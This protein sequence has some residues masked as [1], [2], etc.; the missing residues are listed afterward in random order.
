MLFVK[1]KLSDGISFIKHITFKKSFNFCKIQCSYLLSL[2][3]KRAVFWGVPYS[4]SIEPTSFC[5]LNCPECPTGMNSLSRSSGIMDMNTFKRIIDN[6]NKHLLFINLYFQGEP[7]IN[8]LFF[9]FISY[10]SNKNIY[11]STSTNGHFLNKDFSEKIIE[12][13]LDRIIISLD[14][15]DQ[16]TYTSYRKNGKLDL[17]IE[18]IKNLVEAKK[19]KKSFKPYIILQ[20]L[21][22]KTNELQIPEMKILAR[23][24]GVDELQLKSAQFYDLSK[25]NSLIPTNIKYSRYKQ[26]SNG[27]WVLKKSISNKCFKMWHSC[28]ITWNG[29]VVPCCFDKNADYK[30]GN[31]VESPL[32]E[33]LSNVK[34]IQYRNNLLK[35][36]KS[37]PICKNCNE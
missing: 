20:F 5:N 4:I 25:D 1:A 17:V 22:L 31:I 6:T 23:K 10:A 15:I 33:I 32:N 36:R 3:K 7:F 8:P 37:I 16:D 30:F 21:V 9:D 28:V 29:D 13:G 11:T 12:S 27:N 2:L 26:E 24:L 14:G 34:S 19:I 35:N 18:G